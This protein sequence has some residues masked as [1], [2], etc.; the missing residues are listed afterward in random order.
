[1][2]SNDL[3]FQDDKGEWHH[4]TIIATPQRIVFGGVC[5]AGFLESGY[6]VR[7]EPE[8]LD[9]TLTDLCEDLEA[10]Y[11]HGPQYVSRIIHNERM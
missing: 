1:M 3:E 9:E 7:D 6:I 2:R 8:H 11:N 4:F 10:Y 5:N